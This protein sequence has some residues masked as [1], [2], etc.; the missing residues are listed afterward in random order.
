MLR[1][2]HLAVSAAELTP[3]VAEVEA[4]LGL[5]L[6]PGGAHGAMGTHN[7]LLRMGDVYLEV[8]AV[9]STAPPP[10]RPRWFAL[11][12]FEG[13]PRLTNWVVACDD[14]D[15]ELAHAP[16]GAGAAM[17]LARGDL[18]WRMAVPEDGELPFDGAFPALIQWQ[19]AAHPVQRL[20]DSGLR[21]AR[22]EIVHPDMARMA[23]ALA[24]LRD[25]RVVLSEGRRAMRATLL[26]PD[27]RETVLAG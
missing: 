17:D 16:A 3:G 5:S 14:L 21:L 24:G 19:G 25:A 9:D 1:L 18:R 20:P 6:S 13:A 26:A 10:G 7:R 27:G 12:R 4:L 15:A 23:P 8:I 11:D 2:D 22:L